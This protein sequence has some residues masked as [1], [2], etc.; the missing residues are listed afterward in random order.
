MVCLLKHRGVFGKASTK[1]ERP[2]FDADLVAIETRDN[3]ASISANKEP[4]ERAVSLILINLCK[5]YWFA[6]V[7]CVVLCCVVLC[8]AVL[9]CPI[10]SV[11][12]RNYLGSVLVLSDGI[13]QSRRRMPSTTFFKS[14]V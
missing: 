6:V 4:Q 8:C 11:G 10:Q 13:Q 9:C 14:D 5:R 2:L 12:M 1:N 7:C 3:P